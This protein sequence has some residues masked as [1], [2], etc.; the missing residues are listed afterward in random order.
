MKLMIFGGGG[1]VGGNLALAARKLGWQVAIADSLC[2]QDAP[3]EGGLA[4]DITDK[5]AVEAAIL[6]MMP[7]VAVNVAAVADIDAA[8]R[9][10][11]LAWRVNVEGAAN[12]AAACRKAEVRHVFFSSDA[13]FDG[14]GSG[15]RE[16]DEPNPV[17]FYGQTKAAAEK[18]VLAACPSAAVIRISLVL[19][20]PQVRG[21]SFVGA[22]NA[23]LREHTEVFC[24]SDEIRTPVDVHTLCNCVLELAQ[25][26]FAGILH[27]GGTQSVDR[28]TLTRKL[29][30]A[31]GFD[32][33]LVKAKPPGEDAPGRAPR[34]KNGIICV[35]RAEAI[36]KT[37]ML[38]LDDTIIRA[39]DSERI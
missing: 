38:G 5:M 3:A 28:L 14:K 29:A 8:E 9:N 7:D 33:G 25:N 21:N 16:E 6:A 11:E 32:A 30:V 17:N 24:P 23:K 18:A 20:W 1:F 35:D 37:P 4:V 2:L 34:H 36:L 22:L 10:H 31:M 13:V 15:Y 19:G 39:L 12:I 26:S 27:I